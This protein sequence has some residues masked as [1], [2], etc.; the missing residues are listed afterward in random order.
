MLRL[1]S[2]RRAV[3]VETFQELANLSAGALVLGQ[4][5]AQ[6]PLPFWLILVGAAIWVA[7]VGLALL[8]AG[9]EQW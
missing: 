3:L 2:R 4:F 6:Q 9:A 7:L 1:K 8:F 5:V